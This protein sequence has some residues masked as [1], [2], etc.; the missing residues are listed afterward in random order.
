[1]RLALA[2]DG[3]E[4]TAIERAVVR[5][6][7]QDKVTLLGQRRDVPRLLAAAD[8]LLLTSVSEGVPVTIIEA[9]TAG[10]PVAATSVGGVPELI[11][12]GRTGLLA[13]RGD[14]VTLAAALVRLASDVDLRARLANAALERL[15]GRFSESRMI[16]QYIQ[17]YDEMLN[18]ARS[19]EAFT[20][21]FT[22]GAARA[23]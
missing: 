8:A 2:G 15:D 16:D 3:P 11:D 5:H 13:P 12:D 21:R 6:G 4:R 17:L 23:S 18:A 10:V 7:V 20:Q 14:C 1:M 19:P 22:Q 9:M